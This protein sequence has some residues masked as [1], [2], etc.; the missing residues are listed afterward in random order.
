MFAPVEPRDDVEAHID[1]FLVG[2]LPEPQ[3]RLVAREHGR[4]TAG[5][6]LDAA[7]I[8]LCAGKGIGGPEAIPELEASPRGLG[9]RSARAATSPTPVGSRRTARSASRAGRS[10]PG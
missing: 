1:E 3:A 8:V 4:E 5:Y 7:A 9:P 10:R 2:D 6:E